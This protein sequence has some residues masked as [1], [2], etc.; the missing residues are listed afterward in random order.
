MARKKSPQFTDAELRL[1]DVL[2]S[3]APATVS[4]VIEK[5]AANPPL[6]Y[7]TVIT[8]LRILE[9]K[10]YD[11]LA[12]VK[13]RNAQAGSV[14]IQASS[15]SSTLV[16][17]PVAVCGRASE[18]LTKRGPHFVPMSGCAA[19]HAAKATGANTAPG[20]SS[21]AAMTWSPAPDPVSGARPIPP[22]TEPLLLGRRLPVVALELPPPALVDDLP[23]GRTGVEKAA[24][25]V[26]SGRRA[27][28]TRQGID[29]GHGDAGRGLAQRI[30]GHAN[31]GIEGRTPFALA[32]A[33]NEDAAKARLKALAVAHGGFR[34]ERALQRV[35][36][37]VRPFGGGQDVGNGLADIAE[38]RGAEPADVVEKRRGTEA[39]AHPP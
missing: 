15:R 26:Q 27:L 17:F 22:V 14:Q 8:T 6:A 10:G 38:L 37:V 18:T 30:L 3:K 11:E 39:G 2:W 29:H 21:R 35:V 31:C 7:S 23:D 19:N 28:L 16:T 20:T 5:L 24:V 25:L 13:S 36:G 12:E 9:T 34:A 33:L 1:M 4:A 32:V